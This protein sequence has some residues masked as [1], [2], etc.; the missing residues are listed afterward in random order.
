MA[1]SPQLDKV[2]GLIKAPLASPIHADLYGLSPLLIQLGS[3]ETLLD[4]AKAIAERAKAAS[5]KLE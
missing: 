1:K 2:L 4:D 3:I 5:V